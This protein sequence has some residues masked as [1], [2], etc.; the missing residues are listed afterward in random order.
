MNTPSSPP[1]D[2][3]RAP[4]PWTLTGDAYV[5]LLRL[6]ERLIRE[7]S[8]LPDAL[9][10]RAEGK[11]AILMVVDYS[12]SNVGPYRELLY[13]PCR[14]RVGGRLYWSITRIYVS[15]W[16]SVKNG[17]DNWGIPKDRADFELTREGGIERVKVRKD[18]HV[19]ADLSLKAQLF[20]LPA[21]SMVVPEAMRTLVQVKDGQ[22]FF[23][24]PSAT[25]KARFARLIRASFDPALFP[26]ITQG[27]VLFGAKLEGFKML[28]PAAGIE[29]YPPA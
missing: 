20:G 9:A 13:I 28:F 4:A 19:F 23:Y 1:P 11:T 26:D 3:P 21:S 14:F 6:P 10:G 2:V 5:F 22:S 7:Q 17:R 29:A 18:G 16:D 8:F 24:A 12:S 15:T 25:S 27:S